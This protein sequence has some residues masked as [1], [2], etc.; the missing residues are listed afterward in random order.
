M[1]D[2]E[3]NILIV[4]LCCFVGLLWAIINAAAIAKVNLTGE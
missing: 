2:I 3:F 4:L 1:L